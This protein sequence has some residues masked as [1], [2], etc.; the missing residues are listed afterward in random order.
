M[1]CENSTPYTS[2]KKKQ[3]QSKIQFER[4]PRAMSEYVTKES[5]CIYVLT[6]AKHFDVQTF[7]FDT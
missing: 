7:T 5:V 4:I 2:R 3:R 6:E 1:L